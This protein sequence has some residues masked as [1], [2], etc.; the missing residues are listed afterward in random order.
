SSVTRATGQVHI[1]GASASQ[2]K[3]EL[4]GFDVSDP[5]T[6]E[7]NIRLAPEALNSVEVED[8]RYP[9]QY[10]RGSGG[11]LALDSGMGGNHMRFMGVNFLPSI[12]QRQGL[13]VNGWTPRMVL[14]GPVRNG[15]AWYMD[16]FDGEYR[17]DLVTELPPG[18]N[19]NK[20]VRFSN[21]AK[22]Q[23][24]L[25][26]S[27]ILTA[28]LLVNQ[29]HSPHNGLSPFT[30]LPSTEDTTHSAY[31]AMVKDQMFLPD[32]ALLESGVAV[33]RSQTGGTSLGDEPYTVHPGFVGGNYFESSSGLASRTETFA[34]MYLPE[35]NWLG[36]HT[37]EFGTDEERLGYRQ[38]YFRRPFSVVNTQ[39]ALLRQ[40]AFPGSAAYAIGDLEASGY[41]EDRWW[42]S[43][44]LLLQPGLRIDWD[45][46]VRDA[47]VSPRIAASFMPSNRSATKLVGGIGLYSDAT[48]LGLYTR[49]LGG[50]RLD[51]FYEAGGVL[52]PGPPVE[53]F[54]RLQPGLR[55]PRVWNWSAG[56]EQKLPRNIYLRT[57]FIQKRERDGWAY[58]NMGS[59]DSG[60]L[61]GGYELRDRGHARYDAAKVILRRRFRGG[62]VIF[63]SYVRSAAR[64]N[65]V[66]N[67]TLENPI[68]AMQT[69]GPVPWDSPNRFVSWGLVPLW[70]GFDFAYTADERTGFPFS[71]FNQNQRLVGSP[72]GRRF[73]SYFSLDAAIERRIPLLGFN[74]ELRAGANDL[75]GRHNPYVVENNI[76]SPQFLTYSS[77]QGRTL[78]A[79]LRFLGRR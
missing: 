71:V 23:V 8:S 31:I 13:H 75:T 65:A 60:G 62:H 16:G 59:Q 66:L 47:V 4:D 44:R 45:M 25:S 12:Q 41:A 21:L 56:V 57:E 77:L 63:F 27:N 50:E 40:V 34:S 28:S 38:G 7:F 18:A 78:Q 74:W 35:M 42:V 79:Q 72:E 29:F 43:P 6:R 10:G 64:S 73:P 22:S 24:N 58:F 36:R 11:I 68:F 9:A 76:D 61:G 39:D 32:Q 54:F 2:A 37:F 51:Y 30:P 3:D 48:N 52:A 69:G 1:D 17:L 14:S 53:T 5:V 49:P 19:E 67:F 70:K 55:E 20:L 33:T 46:L 26:Q 15:K